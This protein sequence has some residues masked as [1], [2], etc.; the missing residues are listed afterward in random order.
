MDIIR[1]TL[2]GI[3]FN[4]GSAFCDVVVSG[5]KCHQTLYP[6]RINF[7]HNMEGPLLPAK[8]NAKVTNVNVNVFS[9]F[10]IQLINSTTRD[11]A[12]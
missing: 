2:A 6:S 12:A 9:I 4:I 11:V 7:S 5:V 10:L 3:M 8:N 1:A